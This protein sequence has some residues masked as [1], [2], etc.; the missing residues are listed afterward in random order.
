[1][2]WIGI[3]TCVAGLLAPARADGQQFQPPGTS[4]T[5]KGT[6]IGLFGFG[7]RGGF[8][9]TG[10]SRGQDLRDGKTTLP[11]LLACED[12]AEL[13]AT[14]RAALAAGPPMA[15]AYVSAIIERVTTGG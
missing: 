11:L 9:F 15:E 14:V 10:K 6:R 8:D 13:R 7:V 4:N 3:V 12:D 2:R 5:E 1:M